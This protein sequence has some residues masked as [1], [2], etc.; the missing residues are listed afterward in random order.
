MKIS[1]AVALVKLGDRSGLEEIRK[2]LKNVPKL[3]EN[4]KPFERVR[5][6][7]KGTVRA[8]AARELG[9]LKDSA[10]VPLLKS[11]VNDEDGRVADACLVALARLGEIPAGK[12]SYPLSKA[13]S[14]K[15]GQRPR[16]R[17]AK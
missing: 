1:A 14:R 13:P 5:A 7:A 3:S 8:Q 15:C 17:S 11:M 6:I 12:S 10:S 16:T 9:N 2:I 4:P